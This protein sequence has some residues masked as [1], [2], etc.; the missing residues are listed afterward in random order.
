MGIKKKSRVDLT[1]GSVF[2]TLILFALPI[3]GGS[4]FTQLY[5]LADSVI[6]GQ[7]LGKDALAA[8]SASTPVTTVINLF[9]MGLST[10]STVLIAQSFGAKDEQTIRR[11]TNSIALLSVIVSIALTILGIV[12]CRPLLRLMDTPEEIFHDATLYLIIIFL[13]TLGQA[14]YQLGSGALRGMGDSNW[15]FIFLVACSVMNIILDLIAVPVLHWGVWGAAA[16]T[17][18]SHFVS[19]IG[20]IWRLNHGNYGIHLNLK[21]MRIDKQDAKEIIRIGF[22]ASLQQAGNSLASIFVQSFV[23]VFGVALIAAN[24]VV[25]KVDMFATMPAMAVG[26]AMSSFVGQNVVKDKDRVFKGIRISMLLSF[27]IGVIFCLLLFVSRN[28]LPYA[29][30]DDA[31]VVAI[32]AK[33]LA[34]TAACAIFQGVD[35]CLVN[36]MRGAGKSFIPMITSMFGSFSRIP[37]VYFLAVRTGN[38]NGVFLAILIANMLRAI[39]IVSYYIFLGG[40]KAI[41]EFKGKAGGRG[42]R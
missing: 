31:E 5:N 20:I 25:N 18:L 15:S 10:G 36:A 11:A 21:E 26:T 27:G 19:G 9:L 12:I 16:A 30:N 28:F 33:G 39:A 40:K 17:A 14:I 24:T 38:Q 7:F 32:A 29:F 22:P 3:L 37:L 35:S 1:Q 34:I 8:V 41:S 4:I 23:N 13:G 42:R 6:V 2:K